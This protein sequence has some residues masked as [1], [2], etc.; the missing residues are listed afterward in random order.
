MTIWM[1][2][3]NYAS[4]HV[5]IYRWKNKFEVMYTRGQVQYEAENIM[6]LLISHIIYVYWSYYNKGV[7]VVMIV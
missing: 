5:V 7:V 3:N 4:C 6:E 1:Y 2:T